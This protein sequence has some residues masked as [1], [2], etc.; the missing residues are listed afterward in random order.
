MKWIDYIENIDIYKERIKM[1]KV[2]D[3]EFNKNGR[4]GVY[5]G[6]KGWVKREGSLS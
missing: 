2:K 4:K 1:L 3:E 5:G 6:Y